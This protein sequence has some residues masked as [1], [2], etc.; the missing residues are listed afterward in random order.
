[1]TE[2]ETR[3]AGRGGPRVVV[4]GPCASGKTTLVE[5]LK[6]AGVDAR[7][8]G[9]EHSSVRNLW[10]TLDPDVLIALDLDLDTLRARRHPA[11]PAKL[12][13]VQHTRLAG[14]FDVADLTID[15]GVASQDD[16]FAAAMEL[17]ARHGLTGEPG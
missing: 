3:R 11:W 6:A 15:T 5:R 12:Y 2:D 8:S 7:V 17:I 14:A 4:V 10:R 16:V 9:Q 13:E 1:M